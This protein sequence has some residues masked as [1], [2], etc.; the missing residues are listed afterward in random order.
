MTFDHYFL[1]EWTYSPSAWQSL[2]SLLDTAA[3][4]IEVE[5]F[6]TEAAKVFCRKAYTLVRDGMLATEQHSHVQQ[7]MDITRMSF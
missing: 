7:L 2:I 5:L 3:D 6:A 4:E 1:G